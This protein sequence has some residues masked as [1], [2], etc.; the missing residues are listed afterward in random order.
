MLTMLRQ[1]RT[2]WAQAILVLALLAAG[3]QASL[4]QGFMLDRDGASGTISVVFCT[5]HGAE[6]RWIDLATGETR[7]GTLPAPDDSGQGQSCAF[8]SASAAIGALPQTPSVLVP[9][10]LRTRGAEPADTMAPAAHRRPGPPVR[11]PPARL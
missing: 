5:G 9:T 1:G 8:A 4:P 7:D 10:L 6:Q 11:A 2:L 3:I